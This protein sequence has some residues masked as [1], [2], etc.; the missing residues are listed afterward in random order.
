MSKKKL[1][2]QKVF[3]RVKE[4]SE[5]DTKTGW[6]GELADYLDEHLRFMISKRTLIRYYEAYIEGNEDIDIE[7][8]ILNKLSQYLNYRDYN[9][10]ISTVEKRGESACST[11]VTVDN[12]EISPINGAR[13]GVSVI[14][15]NN[16]SNNNDNQQHFNVPDFIKKNGLGILEMTFVLLLVTGGVVFPNTT[17]N[18]QDSQR[19]FI[20]P[21]IGNSDQQ[22]KYM[23]WDK[24]RYVATDSSSLGPQVEVIPMDKKNF[25]YL[26]KI[27]RP[28]TLTV[29][30]AF[31]KVWYDKSDN[32][33]EFFT[34]FGKH[35]ENGKTLKDASEYI[36]ETYGGE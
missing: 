24:D 32:N 16:N 23:Y 5:R 20:L 10:F 12:S 19:S 17:Q 27:T 33:V 9:D 14:I 35:P 30:N 21:F 31:G 2:I 26:R 8:V 4:N 3:E 13:R 25:R 36:I 22:K 11:I 6:A 15:H 28:D 18:S 1:L 29:D 34:S 7:L